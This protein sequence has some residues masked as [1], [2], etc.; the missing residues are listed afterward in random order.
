[1]Q[2]KF[3]INKYEFILEVY[4][5]ENCKRVVEIKFHQNFPQQVYLYCFTVHF[6]DSLNITH[7]Q[8]HQSYIIMSVV[9][10][11]A[12]TKLIIMEYS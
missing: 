10:T 2:C 11:Y 8:M 7:Q 12:A 3:K 5:R 9:A 1:M 6:E 4:S